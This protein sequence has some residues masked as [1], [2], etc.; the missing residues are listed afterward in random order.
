MLNETEQ[1]R[2]TTD[3]LNVIQ[4][5]SNLLIFFQKFGKYN[6]SLCARTC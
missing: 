6:I 3:G 1:Y 4:K 5:V 2:E